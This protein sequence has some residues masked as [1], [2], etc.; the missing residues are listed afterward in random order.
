MLQTKLA[1]QYQNIASLAKLS[2]FFFSFS[3]SH[4]VIIFA[5]YNK[6]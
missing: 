6:H 5:V 3:F 2:Q 1:G 4:A